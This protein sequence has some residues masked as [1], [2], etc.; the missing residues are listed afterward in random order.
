[1]SLALTGFYGYCQLAGRKR[2]K[3]NGIESPFCTFKGASLL[4]KMLTSGFI[5]VKN[6]CFSEYL[7]FE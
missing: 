2:K 5:I 7:N 4:F 1:M 6:I 3:D